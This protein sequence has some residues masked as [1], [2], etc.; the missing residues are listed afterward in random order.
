MLEIDV[1]LYEHYDEEK[2]VFV[3]T[4]THRVVL[5]HSLLSMSKWESFFEEPFLNDREKSS[6]QTI[7]YV[8]MMNVGGEIPADVFHLLITNHMESIVSYIKAKNTATRLSAGGDPQGA[9]E[10]ITSELIYYWMV[11]MQIPVEFERWHL[12][13]LITLIRIIALKNSPKK[14]MTLTERRN[15]NRQRLSKYNTR[16]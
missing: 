5:E 4:D 6:E 12:N 1:V 3:P 7:A 13:R 8:R 16:G 14:K 10:T 15:L 2:G 9:K 11:S